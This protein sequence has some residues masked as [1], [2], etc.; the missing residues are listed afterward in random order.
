MRTA[1]V[2]VE[3][4]AYADAMRLV[5]AVSAARMRM[6]P[7]DAFTLIQGYIDDQ[8]ELGL[9]PATAW[10]ILSSAGI[11]WA[12]SLLERQ[13]SLEGVC[14]HEVIDRAIAHA[15]DWVSNGGE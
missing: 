10:A 4:S 11:V 7:S 1:Y 8:L 2:G 5:P 13:A 3:A 6:A 14:K 9:E 15:Q 12:T